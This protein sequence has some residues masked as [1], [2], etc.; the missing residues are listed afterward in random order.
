MSKIQ[1]AVG[2]R[3]AVEFDEDEQKRAT[4]QMRRVMRGYV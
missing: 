4:R 2:D 3:I 1:G